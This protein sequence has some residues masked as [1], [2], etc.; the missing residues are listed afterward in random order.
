MTGAPGII[1]QAVSS[2]RP[3]W[4]TSV[5]GT[6]I[7]ALCAGISPIRPRPLELAAIALLALST[8]LLVGLAVL[9]VAQAIRHPAR[10]AATFHNPDEAQAWGAP[11]MGF[12]TVAAGFFAVGPAVIGAT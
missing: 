9:L 8:G 11:P 12:L 7:L 3:G 10:L 6:G 4:F 5:M 2:V 1:S